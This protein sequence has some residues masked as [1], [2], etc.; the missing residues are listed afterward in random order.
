MKP[1]DIGAERMKETFNVGTGGKVGDHEDL[2]RRR[3]DFAV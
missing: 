1:E 2:K 3:E